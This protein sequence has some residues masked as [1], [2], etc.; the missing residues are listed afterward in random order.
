MELP[1]R[2][3]EIYRQFQATNFPVRTEDAKSFLRSELSDKI[4]LITTMNDTRRLDDLRK[5]YEI[6][7][8]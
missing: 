1:Q 4:T 3:T 8:F 6:Y 2:V 5:S 7:K